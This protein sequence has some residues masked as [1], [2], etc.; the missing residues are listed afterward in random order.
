MVLEVRVGD[1]AR[2][3]ASCL[4][5]VPVASDVGKY[6]DFVAPR[7]VGGPVDVIREIEMGVERDPV[8]VLVF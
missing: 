2:L 3:A 1:D 8:L 5:I 4:G 6:L 7:Y